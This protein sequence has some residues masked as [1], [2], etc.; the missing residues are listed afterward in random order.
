MLERTA[1][2]YLRVSTAEQELETQRRELLELAARRGLHVVATYED[3]E[4]GAKIRAGWETC[5]T[6]A[7]R[8]VFNVLLVWALDRV[9]RKLDGIAQA[10][11]ELDELG[12][13]VVSHEEPW[14]EARDDVSRDLLVRV[15]DWI[16]YQA[17]L[18]L[19]QRTRAGLETARRRGVRLGRPPTPTVYLERAAAAL[20]EGATWR[21][22][23]RRH[24]VSAGALSRFLSGRPS[25]VPGEG[26]TTS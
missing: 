16:S 13:V 2:L 22:A 10:V 23:C 5:R 25:P 9:G 15:F 26:I 19:R 11:R 20:R 14:V 21:E 7:R 3:V 1:A 17:R 6:A 8:G 24:K 18:R 4:S 12:V